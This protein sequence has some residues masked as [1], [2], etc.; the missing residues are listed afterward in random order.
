MYAPPSEPDRRVAERG[1]IQRALESHVLLQALF[2]NAPVGIGMLD[3]DF[4][5]VRVNPTLAALNGLPAEAHVGRTPRELFPSLPLDDMEAMWRRVIETATPVLGYEF[6]GETPAAP[7]SMRCWREDWFPVV[8]NGR[9]TGLAV[10]V[11]EV[12][13]EKRAAN[14][15]RLLVGIV[16]HD[17]RNPLAVIATSARLLRAADLGPREACTVGRIERAAHRIEAL[18]RD[19]LDYT[20]ITGGRGLSVKPRHGA[21]LFRLVEAAAE[22]ARIA[23]PD[24]IIE[25]RGDPEVRGEWD[26]DRIVQLAGNLLSNAAKYGGQGTP[27]VARVH[28]DGEAAVL[29][30]HNRGVPIPAERLP[31]VFDGLS[32]WTDERSRQGGIGLGLFI[33]REIVRAHGGTIEITSTRSSGTTVRVRLPRRAPGDDGGLAQGRAR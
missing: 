16:G 5:F 22:D 6:S 10:V 9:V 27:V 31:H 12:T 18:A 4:R 21:D 17:L 20:C 29:E 2:E 11:A 3:T 30:V 25:C 19:L 23:Y 13:E 14:L 26:D 24:A 7:G 15:Q 28:A 1:A 8:A 32:Q 33:C